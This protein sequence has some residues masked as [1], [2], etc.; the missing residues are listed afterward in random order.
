VSIGYLGPG[1]AALAIE[2]VQPSQGTI[3]DGSYPLTRPFLLVTLPNPGSAVTAFVQ[4]AQSVA[5]QA[6]VQRIYAGA[7]SGI[8]R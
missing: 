5:G 6:I 7:S 4:F 3:E 8:R 2:G 1:V